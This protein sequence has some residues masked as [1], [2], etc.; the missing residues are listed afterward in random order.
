MVTFVDGEP[1]RLTMFRRKDDEA[2]RP[3]VLGELRDMSGRH[4]APEYQ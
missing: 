4:L 2:L 1:A 3:L